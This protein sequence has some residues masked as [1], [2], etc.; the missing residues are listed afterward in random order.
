MPR[1]YDDKYPNGFIEVDHING[2]L[3]PGPD[4]FV[5]PRPTPFFRVPHMIKGSQP[6]DDGNL[7]L[8]PE[9]RDE[10]IIK[11]PYAEKFIRPF[12]GSKEFIRRIERYCLWLVDC[13][14]DELRKMP[15]VYQR[16]KNVREFRLK[17]KSAQTRKDADK[18][19]LFQGIR[20]PTT[21]YLLVPSV[22]SERRRYIPIG[23]M[24]ANTIVSN[25]AFAVPDADLFLFGVL[26]SSVHMAWVKLVAGRLRND[27]RYSNTICYNAFPFPLFYAD[28]WKP[29]VEK[30]AQK[31]L[32]AR[33][34]YPNASYADLYDEVSMPYDLRKAHEENDLAV[35][36]FY[37]RLKPEMSEMEMQVALLYMYDAL[38]EHFGEKDDY[39]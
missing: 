11:N 7:L 21:D 26:T 19:M 14:P 1:I 5:Y 31:I 10:L 17:S 8:T 20:Q 32:D 15:L 34:N 36:S 16:A 29:R 30:T 25:L 4:I 12:V 39:E 22:S 24:D 9:E 13:T 3:L 2:Y 6:T 18:P 35:L 28:E 33:A 37:G 23:W 38:L 27:Y